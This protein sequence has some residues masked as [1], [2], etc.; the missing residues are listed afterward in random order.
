ME[1]VGTATQRGKA[2]NTSAILERLVSFIYDERTQSKVL[3]MCGVGASVV[4]TRFTRETGIELGDTRARMEYVQLLKG[5]GW[6]TVDSIGRIK[7]TLEG[8][9]HV[10]ERRNPSQRIMPT[11]AELL[12]RGRR[13]GVIR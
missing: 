8:M 10:E 9:R 3:K 7:L 12:G 2:V 13:D 11:L 6:I 4:L 5:K 1:D